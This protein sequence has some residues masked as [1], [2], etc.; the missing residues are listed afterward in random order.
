MTDVFASGAR[1]RV[2]MTKWGGGAHWAYEAL[3]LGADE[4]GE[5]LGLPAG[6]AYSRP[7]R[8]FSMGYDHVGLV[9]APVNG[10]RRPWHLAAFY[11]D[12]GPAWPALDDSPV[13]VYVDMTTPAEWH[14]TTLRSVDLDLDVV[15]GRNGR[16][17][18]DDEDEFAV[19]QVQLDYPPEVVTAAR[20]SCD[21]VQA[22]VLAG[23]APYDG[24]HR[25]WLDA[26]ARHSHA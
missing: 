5:W 23:E 22:A 4:H 10:V 20:A 25:R 8:E 13:E 14:G 17:I 19:H 6:T 2:E 21:A 24:T 18:V 11:G 9:P 15:R 12:G 16:V 26:L 3:F 1:V 7:G